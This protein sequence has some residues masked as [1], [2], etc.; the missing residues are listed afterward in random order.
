VTPALISS[1]SIWALTARRFMANRVAAAGIIFLSVLIV[2][3]LFAPV[4]T[5]YTYEQQN[6]ELGASAP[7]LAHVFGTDANGRDLLTRVLYGGRVSL[8]VGVCATAVSLLIGVTFGAVSGY[9]GGRTDALMMR[10]VDVLYAQPFIVLVIVLMVVFGR[11]IYL[12]FAAIGAIEWLTMARIV[13]GQVLSLKELPFV[14]AAKVLGFS[15]SRI[16]FRH[17]IPNI[18]GH[19]I[20][21]ATL[22]IPQV[23]LLESFLSFLGLGVQAPMSSWGLLIGDGAAAMETYPWLLIAPGV[24]L[25]G[26]LFSLNFI[27]DGLRDALDPRFTPGGGGVTQ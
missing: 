25:S 2:L 10:F 9:A 13:R 4:L 22:T 23:I 16:L 7:S 3:C 1:K 11:N 24:L 26:T 17:I 27:G 20:V 15:R 6:L 19:V 18:M 12:M 21:Y 8:F 14:K 5:P